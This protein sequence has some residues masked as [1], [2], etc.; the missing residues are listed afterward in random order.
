MSEQ[1]HCWIGSSVNSNG[2]RTIAKAFLLSLCVHAI[3]VGVLLGW[4]VLDSQSSQ[5]ELAE[6]K[7]LVE[8]SPVAHSTTA[9]TPTVRASPA[10][11]L[12]SAQRTIAKHSEGSVRTHA[13]VEQPAA[14][15]PDPAESDTSPSSPAHE[16]DLAD[17][18]GQQQAQDGAQPI[19]LRVLDWLARYRAYPLAARRARIEGTVQLHV[20]L[21][22]DGRLIDVRV[23]R[24]SGHP[25]LD[26]AA[27]ELLAR[28]ARL[29]SDFGSARTEQIEL[30]L[31]IAYRMRTSSS[32]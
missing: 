29:P 7:I 11:K 31:P 14:R 12:E 18:A 15:L 16:A 23:E 19:E 22:P 20:T 3:L 32:T 5:Q 26:Q 24:S 28:A 30:Q 21:M 13:A 27:L 6:H 9:A 1:S 10:P 2:P 25:M 4:L 8:L 17:D